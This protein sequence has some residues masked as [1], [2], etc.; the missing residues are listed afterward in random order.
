MKNATEKFYAFLATPLVPRARI[1]LALLV[2]PLVVAFAAPLWRISMTAPQY[3]DGLSLDVYVH[4][5]EGG[6]DGADIR[7]INILNHYIGMKTIERRDMTDLDWIPF[8]LGFIGILAL[9]CAA[10]G[11]VRA[12]V[13]LTVVTGYVSLFAF[14]RF[15]YKLYTFGHTLNPD[16][17]VK[18]PPFTPVILGTKQ[19]ANFTTSSYPGLGTVL[20]GIFATGVAGVLVWHL[21][22]GRRRAIAEEARA[23]A[24]LHAA[25]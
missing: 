16:A 2:V 14:A 20:I 9:R 17:P 24:A 1:L 6:R 19:I 21:V 5:V 12:L 11:D 15:V 18:I 13:D 10:V 8:A 4:T 22:R 23:V 7:E 25:E 3:P